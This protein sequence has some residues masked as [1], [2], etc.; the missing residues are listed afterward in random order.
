[1][2]ALL[3]AFWRLLDY[4]WGLLDFVAIAALYGERG[5]DR[6]T[7]AAVPRQRIRRWPEHYGCGRWIT[8][9]IKAA[10]RCTALRPRG[11]RPCRRSLAVGSAP[12]Q[13]E[14]S[15]PDGDWLSASS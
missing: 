10:I 15:R 4:P 5:D 12:T 7:P 1:M 9:S 11:R 13:A 6:S 2:T 3:A 14:P 8:P